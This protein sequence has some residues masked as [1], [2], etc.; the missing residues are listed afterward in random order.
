[1]TQ[2]NPQGFDLF[3][4]GIHLPKFPE[5]PTINM[6]GMWHISGSPNGPNITLPKFPAAPNVNAPGLGHVSGSPAGPNI[7]LPR[8][9]EAPGQLGSPKTSGASATYNQPADLSHE[10]NEGYSHGYAE[11][12]R[13]MRSTLTYGLPSSPL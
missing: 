5:P 4:N 7:T 10:Y 8:F 13:Q 2:A 6:P 3:P 9:P 12:Q 11:A 1:M